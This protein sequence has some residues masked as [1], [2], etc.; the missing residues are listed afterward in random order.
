[1]E[2]V[3]VKM[4]DIGNIVMGLGQNCPED[5]TGTKACALSGT[6]CAKPHRSLPPVQHETLPSR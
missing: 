1:M 5:R 4:S 6:V 3:A 2:A